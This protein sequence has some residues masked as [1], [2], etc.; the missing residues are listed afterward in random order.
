[1]IP[2]GDKLRYLT[3]QVRRE[4]VQVHGKTVERGKECETFKLLVL[5][6]CEC[7]DKQVD[8]WVTIM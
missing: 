1:V 8:S 4:V 7:K 2:L 3:R 6:M 5:P